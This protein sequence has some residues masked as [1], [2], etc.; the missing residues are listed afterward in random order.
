MVLSLVL[1]LSDAIQSS[2]NTWYSCVG[3]K[4]TADRA[5]DGDLTTSSVTEASNKANHVE[6]WSATLGN[7][8]RIE[9]ILV[10]GSEYAFGKGYY[11][12]FT[13]K[14]RMKTS[15]SWKVCK[16]D[17]SIKGSYRPHEVKC[18]TPTIAKYIRL[19]VTGF[20][21][22]YLQEVRVLGIP[23]DPGKDCI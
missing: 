12:H 23:I 19:S 4:C 9:K 6:W 16:G 20:A 8:S 7:P 1:R 17:Y 10:Y 22:L 2:T 11:R 15:D 5:I 14:T 3:N 21:S 13:V 18:N